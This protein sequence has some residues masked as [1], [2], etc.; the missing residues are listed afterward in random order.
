MG[1][2]ILLYN[3]PF[4]ALIYSGLAFTDW[5]DSY[6]SG[7]GVNETGGDVHSG[8]PLKVQHIP[9]DDDTCRQVMGT[10]IKDGR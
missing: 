4:E 6:V 2:I 10:N 9:V 8:P 3:N 1:N 7:W 5:N